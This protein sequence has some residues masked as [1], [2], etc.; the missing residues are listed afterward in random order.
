M[1]FTNLLQRL[2]VLTL[3]TLLCIAIAACGSNGGPPLSTLN[4]WGDYAECA[5]DEK[6]LHEVYIELNTELQ[7]LAESTEEQYGQAPWFKKFAGTRV[8]N[9][10]VVM[11]VLFD[12]NG[13]A[14]GFRV[15]TDPRAGLQ[16]RAQAYLLALRILPEYGREGWSCVD[17]EPGPR[18]A[19]VGEFHLN[20]FC[21]KQT[22]GKLVTVES[23]LFRK[24]GQ[25]GVDLS[26]QPVPGDY[27]SLT[28]WEVYD[29]AFLDALE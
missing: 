28:I 14:R 15:V 13:I 27:E 21:Q 12:S 9:F 25:T 18:E 7:R 11:S 20:R 26:G 22:N 24:A 8:A 5:A 17:R 3:C 2:H 16:E 19:P 4:G 23:H 10:A 1:E 29:Q 6:G